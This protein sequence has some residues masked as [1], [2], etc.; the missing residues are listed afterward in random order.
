MGDIKRVRKKYHRPGHPWNRERIAAE[1]AVLKEYGLKNKTELWK[2]TSRLRSFTSQ[3]KKLIAAR[4]AQSEKETTLFLNKLRSYGFVGEGASL[5][6][7]L[8]LQPKHL[9]DR[10]L[11]TL[12]VRKNLARTMQQ[13]RQFIVHGHISVGTKKI[14]SPTYLVRVQEETTLGFL[15][16][17]TLAS[18]EHPERTIAKKETEKEKVAA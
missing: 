17:S 5:D 4:T 3:A 10:R 9:L 8:S 2:I 11:Q 16:R 13:A 15:S 6:A 1:K 7:V 18:P 12:L 14:T